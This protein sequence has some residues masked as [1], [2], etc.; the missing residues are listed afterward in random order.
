MKFSGKVWPWDDL[1]QFWVNS[2]KSRDP[3]GRGLLCF[4][5]SLFIPVIFVHNY[6]PVPSYD[7]RGSF[8]SNYRPIHAPSALPSFSLPFH[9]SHLISLHS[10]SLPSTLLPSL[11]PF[12]PF[13]HPLLTPHSQSL[14]P[15]PF[16]RSW[17][18]PLPFRNRNCI[19]ALKSDLWSQQ[20]WRFSWESN[21]WVSWQIS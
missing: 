14:P 12:T 19:F 21:N 1:I 13:F 8:F 9:P 20:F 7:G 17:A 4:C 5:T 18:P 2:E 11:S 6:R 16:L 10:P 3:L 15:Y